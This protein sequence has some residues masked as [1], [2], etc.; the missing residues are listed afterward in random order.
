MCGYCK[1]PPQHRV[2]YGKWSG[3]AIIHSTDQTTKK[4]HTPF[5]LRPPPKHKGARPKFGLPVFF[6]WGASGSDHWIDP[7]AGARPGRSSSSLLADTM[8]EEGGCDPPHDRMCL[9][10]APTA[11]PRCALFSSTAIT[12]P[13][14]A[15]ELAAAAG[16]VGARACSSLAR[17][18]RS[19]VAFSLLLAASLAR[20]R[21]IA[22]SCAQGAAV[23]WGCDGGAPQWH[24]RAVVLSV[25]T[26][27]DGGAAAAE[28]RRGRRVGGF[29]WRGNGTWRQAVSGGAG[30]D[31]WMHAWGWG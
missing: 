19:P 24:G 29:E 10:A 28:G 27:H 26:S 15:Q 9:E 17:R 8:T 31:G 16:G 5:T 6:C 12:S 14:N 1:P 22:L 7:P 25:D 2:G 11:P 13:T 4:P 21:S 30:V 20:S 18:R 3:Y 23:A